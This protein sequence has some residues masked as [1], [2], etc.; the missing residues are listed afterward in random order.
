MK[1]KGSRIL[2]LLAV[3]S[4]RAEDSPTLDLFAGWSWYPYTYGYPYPYGRP[5]RS[6]WLDDGYVP[7]PY[8]GLSRMWPYGEGPWAYRYGYAP[9]PYGWGFD[10]GVRMRIYPGSPLRLPSPSDTLLAPFPGSAPT[11]LK[12]EAKEKAWDPDIA[13]FLA[14][15]PNAADRLAETNA[16]SNR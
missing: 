12:D 1:V 6:G 14:T 7:Y 3:L 13:S 2:L 5:Y 10:Y 8:V 11:A 16:P 4:L 15:L 9:Y